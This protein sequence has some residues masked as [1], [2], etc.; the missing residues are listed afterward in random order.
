[1][2]RKK[3]CGISNQLKRSKF[4]RRRIRM[5]TLSHP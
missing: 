5:R 2:G 3:L 4:E 1:M